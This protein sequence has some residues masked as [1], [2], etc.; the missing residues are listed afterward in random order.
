MRYLHDLKEMLCDELEQIVRQGNLNGNTLDAVD[1]IT[2]SI[3]SLEVVMGNSYDGNSRYSRENN[4]NS[5]GYSE[6]RRARNGRYARDSYR[7]SRAEDQMAEKLEKIMQEAPDD[8]T[9]QAIE[10]AL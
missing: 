7:Y 2:H 5:Y 8:R 6:R 10:R 3:K 4:S 9:R 1:K